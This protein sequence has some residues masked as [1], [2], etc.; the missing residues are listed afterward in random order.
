MRVLFGNLEQAVLNSQQGGCIGLAELSGANP[1]Y[2]SKY[3]N[4]GTDHQNLSFRDTQ[5]DVVAFPDKEYVVTISS[6]LANDFGLV[7][8]DFERPEN[9]RCWF[10]SDLILDAAEQHT[11]ITGY[12]LAIIWYDVLVTVSIYRLNSAKVFCV[13]AT[14]MRIKLRPVFSTLVSRGTGRTDTFTDLFQEFKMVSCIVNGG[15]LM[16]E[17]INYTTGATIQNMSDSSD[18]S[19]GYDPAVCNIPESKYYMSATD[20]AFYVGISTSNAVQYKLVYDPGFTVTDMSTY[21]DS[22]EVYV[23][24]PNS[25]EAMIFRPIA[26]VPIHPNC[27]LASQDN[28][29]DRSC[30]S[31]CRNPPSAA[32]NAVSPSNPANQIC[33]ITNIAAG[34]TAAAG[35][36]PV[37]SYGDYDKWPLGNIQLRCQGDDKKSQVPTPPTPVAAPPTTTSSTPGVPETSGTIWIILGIL[38]GLGLGLVGIITCCCCKKAAAG[39]TIIT[40]Q[41][42]THHVVPGKTSFY[43]QQAPDPYFYDQNYYDPNSQNQSYSYGY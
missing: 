41:R 38:G 1:R 4:Q 37:T 33:R 26:P 14:D 21:P 3:E 20:R 29:F 30:T 25:L 8:W 32:V 16:C 18:G 39:R 28:I 19:A 24:S 15:S 40:K 23:L 2:Y 36:V 5:W 35:R 11:S 27:N 43:P 22:N 12:D 17:V 9:A 6:L 7:R 42:I 13:D 34:T 10:K 31:N